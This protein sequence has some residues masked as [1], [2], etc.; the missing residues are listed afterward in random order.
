MSKADKKALDGKFKNSKKGGAIKRDRA[1]VKRLEVAN[2]KPTRNKEGKI[3]YQ[4]YQSHDKSHKARVEPNRK[5]F[6]MLV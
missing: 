6:G 3:L 1:T 2:A 4:A 5:W